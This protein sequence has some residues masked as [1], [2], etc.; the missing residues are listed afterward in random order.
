MRGEGGELTRT[1]TGCHSTL[2]VIDGKRWGVGPSHQNTLASTSY[3]K[4]PEGHP[5]SS[6]PTC[7]SLATIQ[8]SR[9]VNDR[10]FSYHARPRQAEQQLAI[11]RV[12]RRRAREGVA[13]GG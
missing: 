13:V 7:L 10:Q 5:L 1:H 12:Q 11:E 2:S 4:V 3:F 6:A 8:N 9:A